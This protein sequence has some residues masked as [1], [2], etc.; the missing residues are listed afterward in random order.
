MTYAVERDAADRSG[1]RD[2]GNPWFRRHHRLP[3]GARRHHLSILRHL[4][5]IRGKHSINFGGEFR[6]FRNNNFNGGTGGIYPLPVTGG[7]PRWYASQ[8]IET[9]LPVTPALRVSAFGVF[10]QDDFKVL[11]T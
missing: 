11:R 9:S 6:R 5:W 1:Q 2:T 8:D 3:A 7:V 10:A 4:A